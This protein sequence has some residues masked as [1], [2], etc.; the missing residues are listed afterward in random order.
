MSE[1]VLVRDVAG[2]KAP[3]NKTARLTDRPPARPPGR[4]P[5]RPPDRR[6]DC[7]LDNPT[8]RPPDR[9]TVSLPGCGRGCGCGCGNSRGCGC[10]NSYGCGHQVSPSLRSRPAS[11]RASRQENRTSR[12]GPQI[13]H[14]ASR[15][16]ALKIARRASRSDR[17]LRSRRIAEHLDLF[18]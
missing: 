10:G 13:A 18:L 3:G 2:C 17:D 16:I 5:A 11:D 9:P 12:S 4:P 15:S 7:L 1:S 8:A 14:R 6:T